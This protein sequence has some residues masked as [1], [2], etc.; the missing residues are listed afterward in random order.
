MIIDYLESTRKVWKDRKPDPDIILQKEYLQ[1]QGHITQ[2]KYKNKREK[3]R[4]ETPAPESDRLPEVCITYHPTHTYP[5]HAW[6]HSC[7]EGKSYC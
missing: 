4:S 1:A 5:C 7:K 6:P 2:D 3:V